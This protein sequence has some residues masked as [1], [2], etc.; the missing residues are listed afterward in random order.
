MPILAEADRTGKRRLPVWA[1]VFA[2]V[3]LLPVA[4][5]AWSCCFPIAIGPW[6]AKGITLRRVMVDL[7]DQTLHHGPGYSWDSGLDGW[8]GT[9]K[10]PGGEGTG[11]YAIAWKWR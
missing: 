11:W 2:V 5:F 3:A 7:S 8:W 10:L 1:L 6:P 9:F 4:L